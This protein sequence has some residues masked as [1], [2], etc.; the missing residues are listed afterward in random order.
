MPK[1]RPRLSQLATASR[2]VVSRRKSRRIA[3][4]SPSLGTA[5]A[6]LP[7]DSHRTSASVVLRPSGDWVN[8]GVEVAAGEHVTLIGQGRL[9]MSARLGLSCSAKVALWYR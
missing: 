9:W 3:A 6:V 7:S 2:F 5:L 4:V 8:T 1:P